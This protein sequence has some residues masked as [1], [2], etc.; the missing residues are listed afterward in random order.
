MKNQKMWKNLVIGLC[1]SALTGCSAGADEK[2][3]GGEMY[4]TEYQSGVF[5]EEEMDAEEN[6]GTENEDNSLPDGNGT[7]GV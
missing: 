3:E 5:D 7:N 6:V 1:L 2:T 4:G